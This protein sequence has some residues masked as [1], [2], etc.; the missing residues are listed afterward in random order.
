MSKPIIMLGN[1][2]HASVL[3]E[4]LLS[5]NRK[6]IGFTAPQKE[7][8]VFGISYIGTDEEIFRFNPNEIQLV[9]GIGSVKV[10][11]IRRNLFH[12]FTHK[13]YGF[14]NVIHPSAILS[15]SVRLGQGVQIM[16]GAIVQTNTRIDDN[17]IVNT[18]TKVDHDCYIGAH[19]H[20]A[21]GVT[22]SGYVKI[23]VGSHLGTG[24][25]I[26]QE[27]EI[28]KDCLIGAGAVV[29]KN[30]ANGTKALGVPA[31]EVE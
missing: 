12:L 2:G 11:N 31:K 9:L 10:S 25:T 22:I 19:V 8:N 24:T 30:I 13:Q 18:G 16:A 27:V 4:I 6:V 29:V 7:E 21:P 15:P 17:T 26:I 28:G 1:G 20:L 23:G 3:T 5:Q 14:L